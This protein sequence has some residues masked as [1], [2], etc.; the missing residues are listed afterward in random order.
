MSAEMAMIVVAMP[1]STVS[2]MRAAVRSITFPE[3]TILARER[4]LASYEEK[5]KAHSSWKELIAYHTK[6]AHSD[7]DVAYHLTD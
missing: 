5:G 4:A 3:L 1:V 2:R 7:R 6:H